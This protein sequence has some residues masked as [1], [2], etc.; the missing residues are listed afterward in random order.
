VRA[1]SVKDDLEPRRPSGAIAGADVLEGNAM[2]IAYGDGTA[3][4]KLGR[5]VALVPMALEVVDEARDTIARMREENERMRAEI[6]RLRTENA[7]L[8][9]ALDRTRA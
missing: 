3:E 2:G 7:E 8:K 4:E 9:A 5:L 6:E 1:S